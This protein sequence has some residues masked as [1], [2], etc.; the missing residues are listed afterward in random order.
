MS[1]DELIQK[2][3]EEGTTPDGMDADAYRMVFHALKKEPDV[4]LPND[5]AMRVAS[6]AFAPKKSFDW[7]KF[8]LFA[9]LFA[10]VIALVY[11]IV[12]TDFKFSAG[13]F[14]FVNE[15]PYLMVFAV[16]IIGVLQWIDRKILRATDSADF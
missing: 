11:A 5:F 3:I 10:L 1:E 6:I 14:Q 16:A 13:A 9:G 7:D 2:Q 12:V 4:N 8:F 15:Y